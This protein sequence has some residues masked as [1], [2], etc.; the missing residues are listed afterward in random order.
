MGVAAAHGAARNL[1]RHSTKYRT[2]D[3]CCFARAEAHVN[4]LGREHGQELVAESLEMGERC[5]RRVF[6]ISMLGR[7]LVAQEPTMM[8][9]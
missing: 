1:S 4:A 8:S 3:D 6:K 9:R 2:V 5:D 7:N